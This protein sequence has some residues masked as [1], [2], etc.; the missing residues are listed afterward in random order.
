MS[1]TKK[2]CIYCKG[3]VKGVRKGEHVVPDALGVNATIR[4]VCTDCN[5]NE[6]SRLD[7]EL[8]TASPLSIAA[9]KALNTNGE[10]V[11]DYSAKLDLALEGRLADDLDDVVV[12]W[13]QVVLDRDQWGIFFDV[14]E[15]EKIG[16][17]IYLETFHRRLLEAVLTVRENNNRPK[18]RWRSLQNPPRRGR[19]PPR[20]FTRHSCDDLS[21]GISFECRYHGKIDQNQILTTLENWRIDVDDLQESRED[22]V[23]DPE[24]ATSYRPRWINRAL[25]KIGINLLAYVMQDE[26]PQDKLDEAIRF[27]RYDAGRGPSSL[28]CGF[29]RHDVTVQLGC[30]EDAHK[31]RLQHDQNWTLDCS[32][33]GGAIG[34]TIAF[35]GPR[36]NKARRVDIVAPI[37]SNEWE[38]HQSQVLIPRSPCVTD[39]IDIMMPSIDIRN[40]QTRTRVV[41]QKN[42][43]SQGK[44]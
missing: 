13:P 36:W 14:E 19:F 40:V 35:P 12:R 33:F 32:F 18:L 3:E 23:N 37:G 24:Q 22:G 16:L 21:K 11:W 31:F 26:F 43:R 34:A 44:S 9:R 27:V 10:N 6:L 2:I 39:Q 25:V 41:K 42:Q 15:M 17:Q 38:I 28:E 30:P 29:L 20:I 5:I 7:K 8:V 4:R 1:A